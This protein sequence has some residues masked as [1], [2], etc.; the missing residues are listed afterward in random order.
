[1]GGCRMI[2]IILHFDADGYLCGY[3]TFGGRDPE[4]EYALNT[5][6]LEVIKD[7]SDKY[8][9]VPDFEIN[10]S[11]CYHIVDNHL[12]YDEYKANS[13]NNTILLMKLRQQRELDCFPIINRGQLWFEQLSEEQRIELSK[14]YRNWLDVTVTKIIPEKPDWIK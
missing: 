9:F 10:N 1:M 2:K 4:H 6:T 12:E 7:S 3:S 14:W 11:S 8:D 13:N 5:D